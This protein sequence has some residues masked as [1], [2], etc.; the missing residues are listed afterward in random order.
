MSL[1]GTW[2]PRAGWPRRSD[3]SRVRAPTGA[4]MVLKRPDEGDAAL[5]DV[6]LVE[7]LVKK[8]LQINAHLKSG[9]STSRYLEQLRQQVRQQVGGKPAAPAARSSGGSR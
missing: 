4:S 8:S 9:E 2:A 1:S 6:D 7:E 5:P 3:H